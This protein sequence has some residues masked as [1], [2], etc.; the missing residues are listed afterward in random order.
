MRVGLYFYQV[1]PW[2]R[3]FGRGNVKILIFEDMVGD[4]RS[5]GRGSSDGDGGGGGHE[6]D[7]DDDSSTRVM[8]ETAR[9][10]HDIP[11]CYLKGEID[12]LVCL[13]ACPDEQEVHKHPMPSS[14]MHK[15]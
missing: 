12:A 9:F 10:L 5:S 13:P 11:N 6:H 8:A 4:S 14:A 1:E 3:A 7:Q 2:L 15:R